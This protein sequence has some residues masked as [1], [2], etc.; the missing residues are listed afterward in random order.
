M[1]ETIYQEKIKTIV[2]Q[3]SHT[4]LWKA[5]VL[6]KNPDVLLPLCAALIISIF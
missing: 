5:S 4:E 1:L 3:D 2:F 6:Q